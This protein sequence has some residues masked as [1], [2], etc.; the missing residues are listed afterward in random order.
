MVSIERVPVGG[1]CLLKD[2]KGEEGVSDLHRYTLGKGGRK[3]SSCVGMCKTHCAALGRGQ[4]PTM[5]DEVTLP[6]LTA[7]IP[8]QD[9]PSRRFLHAE[10]IDNGIIPSFL[11]LPVPL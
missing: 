6:Y 5:G 7:S 9:V 8:S 11:S 2:E 3:M 10:A 4:C 1:G